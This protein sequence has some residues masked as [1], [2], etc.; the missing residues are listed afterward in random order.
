MQAVAVA[1]LSLLLAEAFRLTAVQA[2]VAA[3]DAVEA[4]A[5]LVQRT[6]AAVAVAAVS[7]VAL[8][9]MAQLAVQEL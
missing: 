1:V 3:A 4:T 2:A 8:Y 7:K 9:L 6:Q 5:L